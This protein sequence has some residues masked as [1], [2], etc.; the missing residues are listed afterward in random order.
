[1]GRRARHEPLRTPPPPG[2][3]RPAAARAARPA[4]RAARLLGPLALG[5]LALGALVACGRGCGEAGPPA[6]GSTPAATASSP[7]ALEPRLRALCASCHRFAEPA[8]LPRWAWPAVVE[9]MFGLMRAQGI[10]PQGLSPHEVAGWFAAR[11]PEQLPLRPGTALADEPGGRLRWRRRAAAPPGAPPLPGIANVALL[12]LDGDARLELVACDMR[13]GLVL[14]GRPYLGGERTV[15]LRVIARL[16]GGHPAHAEL[17]DLDGDGERDLLVADLGSLRPADHDRGRVWWLRAR[18]DGGFLPVVLA[19]RLGRV[20]DVRP[21]D[22]DGDGDVDLVVAE[23]GWR[24]TGRVLVLENLGVPPAP[25]P[26]PAAPATGAPAVPRFAVHVLDPRP[27]AIHVPVADLD[28]DGRPDVL[29]LL[30]QQHEAVVAYRNRGGLRFEA[31]EL[32]RAPHPAWGSS[33]MEVC[34]LDGDGDLDVLLTNGDTLDD[35]VLKPYHGIRWLEHRAGLR[36]TEHPLADMYGV[37][38][39]VAADLDGDGDLD[40]VACAFLPHFLDEVRQPLALPAVLWLEQTAPG[41][42][43]PARVLER[44]S[45][46]YPTL[47]AGDWDRDGDPDLALGSFTVH[48]AARHPLPGWVW[49]WENRRQ[50]AP[51]APAGAR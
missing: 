50:Q 11:A 21:A 44:F 33:G 19:E 9:D 5:P 48:D 23:F 8:V 43:A 39:A 37:H 10:E 16:P 15:P 13:H 32:Y 4:A 6:A 7:E 40:V 17:V 29:A 18:G 35:H 22:L 30:S 46:D 12:D 36:F 41:R 28:G 25:A 26:P 51:A 14:L 42:F 34:D 27:G 47:A 31:L 20:A 2:P 1:M 45:V 24:Q 38:R 49:L 3:C